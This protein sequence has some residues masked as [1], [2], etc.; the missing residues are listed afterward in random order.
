M[1]FIHEEYISIN[2]AKDILRNFSSDS[3]EISTDFIR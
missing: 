1:F 2:K 3:K